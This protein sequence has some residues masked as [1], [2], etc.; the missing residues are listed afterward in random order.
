MVIKYY[1]YWMS[2]KAAESRPI[3]VDD[4]LGPEP[5][6]TGSEVEKD[7]YEPVI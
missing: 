2:Q 4:R 3:L 5:V 1:D 7:H 6:I